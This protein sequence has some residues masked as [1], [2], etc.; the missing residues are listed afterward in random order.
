MLRGTSPTP[1]PMRRSA[2]LR[3]LALAGAARLLL[4]APAA[5][6]AGD[7]V[8]APTPS[9]TSR[10]AAGF[11]VGGER[12]ERARLA[13]V[14][15]SQGTAGY[16]LRSAGPGVQSGP[17]GP[18]GL[19]VFAPEA[20]VVFNSDLPFSLNEGS[21]WAGRGVSTRVRWGAQARLGGVLLT[22]L[23]E[24]TYSR[25]R[26]YQV[27]PY[28][29]GTDVRNAYASPFHGFPQS[30]DLPSR[31]GADAAVRLSPGQSSLVIPAGAF[32]FG[33]ATAAQ[34]WGP[35]VRN[36]LV[37][38]GNAPSIPHAFFRTGRPLRTGI[39]EV[40]GVW[41]LG[42]LTESSYFD[43][44]GSNKYRSLSAFAATFRPAAEPGLTLGVTRA[45]YSPLA[46]VRFLP[47]RALDAFLPAHADTA[48]SG[49]DREQ[50][51]GV[52]GRW[53][54]PESGL[55]TY[56]EWA[57]RQPPGSLRELLATPQRG[58][59]YTVGLQWAHPLEGDGAFR[60]QA[61]ATNLQQD[62]LA[63]SFYTSSV[64]A[65]GYTQRGRTIGAA[66]GPGASSQWVAADLFRPAWRMGVSLG[67]YRWEDDAFYQFYT[68]HTPV[69]HDVSLL[70]GVHLGRDLGPFA[71]DGEVLSGTR[72]NYLFQN[73]SNSFSDIRAVDVRNFTAS[74][75]VSRPVH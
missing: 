1:F 31:F 51:L 39:G 54:F 32:R 72:Y 53:V 23:P 62:S 6:Q 67:R 22:L 2:A 57:T 14:L 70:G 38:S 13:Q 68:L 12:D 61:E 9:D 21:L 42:W 35:G 19:T 17:A 66:I 59:A 60:V 3:T 40:E 74:L 41:M 43:F 50:I 28:I 49:R 29:S 16:L 24:A 64:V 30:A 10:N 26:R 65:Q 8:R 33:A 20:R 11:A 34:W 4:P 25:N 75:T 44:R 45:V 48:S 73:S 5:A 58:R 36:A 55:E 27:R 56:F 69:G 18:G 15:G 63:Q 47:S 52:F 7:S 46:P 71:L 37:M